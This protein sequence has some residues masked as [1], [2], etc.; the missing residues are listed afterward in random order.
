MELN[1][2]DTIKATTYAFSQKY[3]DYNT[4]KVGI[5]TDMGTDPTGE[6]IFIRVKGKS[7]EEFA[8]MGGRGF[9]FYFHRLKNWLSRKNY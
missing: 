4:E 5:I 3:M 8:V 2:G 7:R 9:D 1:V 6:D